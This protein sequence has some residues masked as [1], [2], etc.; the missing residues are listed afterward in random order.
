MEGDKVIESTEKSCNDNRVGALCGY[1]NDLNQ[2]LPSNATDSRSDPTR[3]AGFRQGP[4]SRNDRQ[5]SESRSE[6]DIP[7]VDLTSPNTSDQVD[8]NQVEK[9]IDSTSTGCI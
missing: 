2:L 6:S 9:S 4:K 7:V 8:S 3:A 5:M 1:V